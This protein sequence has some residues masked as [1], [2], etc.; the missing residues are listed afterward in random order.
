MIFALAS[1]TIFAMLSQNRS[2]DDV[3]ALVK[4]ACRSAI[5]PLLPDKRSAARRR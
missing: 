3:R 4:S 2:V 5:D 1:F